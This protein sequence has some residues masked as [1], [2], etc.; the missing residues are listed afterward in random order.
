MYAFIIL[1][2]S[3]QAIVKVLCVLGTKRPNAPLVTEHTLIT[4]IM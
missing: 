2:A 1:K 4:N 3:K